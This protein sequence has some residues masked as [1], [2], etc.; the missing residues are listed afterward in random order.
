MADRADIP[1]YPIYT[2][3]WLA[4]NI[5][6]GFTDW[7]ELKGNDEVIVVLLSL[8]FSGVA[9]G[10]TAAPVA[11]YKRSPVNTGGTKTA[12]TILKHNTSHADAKAIFSIY[13]ANATTGTSRGILW[14]T[15]VTLVA[16]A[17]S[18]PAKS[19]T[20]SGFNTE[21]MLLKNSDESFN[22]NLNGVAYAGGLSS[23]TIT[24][25]EIPK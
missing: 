19:G 24:W 10:A 11:L 17:S 18:S 23:G 8:E 6:D 21:S 14:A 13:S 3:G 7:A 4:A 22:I 20:V 16:T 12:Q 25:M 15:Y 5:A 1:A 9:T 2:C